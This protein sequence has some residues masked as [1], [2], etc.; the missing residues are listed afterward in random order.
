MGY[1]QVGVTHHSQHVDVCLL[2]EFD[3]DG[4]D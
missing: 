3:S 1:L 2:A 4:N